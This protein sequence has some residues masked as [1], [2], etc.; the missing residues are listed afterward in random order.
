MKCPATG[1]E[2][3]GA[4]AADS[5][6]CCSQ[7]ELDRPVFLALGKVGAGIR[8]KF[9]RSGRDPL[10]AHTPLQEIMSVEENM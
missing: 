10:P 9:K 7:G 5:G 2:A 4:E 6:F 8:T 1:D 3:H